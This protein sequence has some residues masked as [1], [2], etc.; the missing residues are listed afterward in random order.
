MIKVVC[1][2]SIIDAPWTP[3]P[4]VSPVL[5]L[6]H[7]PHQFPQSTSLQKFLLDPLVDPCSQSLPDTIVITFPIPKLHWIPVNLGTESGR[8]MI[9]VARRAR[10]WRTEGTRRANT[11]PQ[12]ANPT[13]PAPLMHLPC[14]LALFET[15]LPATTRVKPK[16]CLALH[17]GK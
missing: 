2:S 15:N 16:E 3:S 12:L 14:M 6:H 11:H 4:L 7:H 8:V 13:F 17:P 10:A 9:K 1:R 5:S